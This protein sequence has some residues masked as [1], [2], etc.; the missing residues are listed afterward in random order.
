MGARSVQDIQSGLIF[1]GC[2]SLQTKPFTVTRMTESALS[3]II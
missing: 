2:L 3:P 1:A